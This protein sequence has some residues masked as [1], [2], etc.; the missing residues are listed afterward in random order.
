MT[1]GVLTL[2]SCNPFSNA[3][4]SLPCFQVV[5]FR[6]NSWTSLWNFA[7]RCLFMLRRFP[8]SRFSMLSQR[9]RIN[10]F[11]QDWRNRLLHLSENDWNTWRVERIYVFIVRNFR[12][13]QQGPRYNIL[14][15]WIRCLYN[16][17]I[18]HVC[19]ATSQSINDRRKQILRLDTNQLA[20]IRVPIAH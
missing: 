7:T 1:G 11:G 14:R 3:K 10:S 4:M 8:L 5:C 6:N 12:M 19:V 15:E 9:N 20:L 13:F 2:M 16:N 18:D 17:V